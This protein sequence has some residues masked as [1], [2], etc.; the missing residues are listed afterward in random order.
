MSTYI[1]EETGH[2]FVIT[3]LPCPSFVKEY[4]NYI[5]STKG[6]TENTAIDYYKKVSEF[7]KWTQIR[8]DTNPNAEKLHSIDISKLS[9][10]IVEEITVVDL[11]EYLSFCATILKNSAATRASKAT[12]LRSFFHYY[13]VATRRLERNPAEALIAP[14][15]QKKLPKYLTYEEC[16]Q[17]VSQSREKHESE[18]P[19]RDFCMI[20]IFLSCGLRI[21]ELVGINLSDIK[22][23]TLK[24]H[25]KG[26]KEREV[27]LNNACLK[28][29]DA[30]RAERALVKGSGTEP[31][32]FL[33][34]RTG[35]RLTDRRVRAIAEQM[36]NEAGLGDM[37]Y[38]VHTL[39]HSCATMLYNQGG[40]DVLELQR[41]L[42]HSSP[43]VTEIYTHLS[44]RNIQRVMDNDLLDGST[45][46]DRPLT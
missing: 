39:R 12:V 37:K 20:V 18:M 2:D 43:T 6:L 5:I 22:D 40:A 42:G 46:H 25:G 19:D 31:A 28:A 30:Y 14:K 23:T 34:R 38:T 10:D 8:S 32:L 4:L 44:D 26:K 17:L 45:T 15:K 7:L 41:I 11:N 33:S 3:A 27:Y 35:H 21:S 1:N 29:L 24:V 36:L 16:L 9:F 13:S